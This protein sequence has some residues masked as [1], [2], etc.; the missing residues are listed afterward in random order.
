[1]AEESADVLAVELG[2][3]RWDWVEVACRP[4]GHLEVEAFGDDMEVIEVGGE[5]HGQSSHEKSDRA[6]EVR[7]FPTGQFRLGN[8][9]LTHRHRSQTMGRCLF[10]H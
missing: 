7:V 5:F 10:V 3:V 6:H 2:Q 9:S 8:S 4:P 1:M